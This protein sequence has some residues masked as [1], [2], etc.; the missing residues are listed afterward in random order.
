MEP[1][2]AHR[3]AERFGRQGRSVEEPEGL[4]PEEGLSG[5]LR[6]VGDGVEMWRGVKGASRS[7]VSAVP[8]SG[9]GA[10]SETPPVLVGAGQAHGLERESWVEG[11]GG[12]DKSFWSSESPGDFGGQPRRA[13]VG[14]S[15]TGGLSTLL[16]KHRLIPTAR[17][18]A[19]EEAVPLA[20]ALWRAGLPLLEIDLA[21]PVAFAGISAIRAALADFTVGAGGIVVPG[22]VGDALEAG[23]MFGAGPAMLPGVLAAALSAELPFLPGAM[24]PS[25]IAVGMQAGFFIQCIYPAEALGAGMVRALGEPYRSSPLQLVPRGGL[26]VADFRE[27]L[28]IPRVGAVAGGFLCERALIEAC[29]WDDIEA[30]ALLCRRKAQAIVSEHPD[31]LPDGRQR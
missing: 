31:P 17:L 19:L 1:F 28:A 29:M 16:L 3:E 24:T 4:P 21:T 8:G 7:A 10:G 22:Q 2:K 25:D 13:S 23:A 9:E 6:E 18:S 11:G 15:Q 5:M 30:Q 14:L 27:F 12:R 26:S 20:E